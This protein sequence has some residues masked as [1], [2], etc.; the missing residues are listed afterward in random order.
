MKNQLGVKKSLV[1]IVVVFLFLGNG[2]SQN[3]NRNGLINVQE[4]NAVGDGKTDDTQAIQKS[5]SSAQVGDT[6]FI[7]EGKY[8]VKALGL[9]SG[10]HIRAEGLLIQKLAGEREEFS[11]SKQN[12]S[13]P[14]FRGINVSD[15]SLSFKAQ[16]VHEAIYLS[17][18]KRIQI[19]NS[20]I[21]GDSKTLKSFAGILLY[22]CEVIEITK[23]TISHFGSERKSPHTYQPGTAIRI[24]SSKNISVTHNQIL[25]N[26]E[27]GVFMHD[28]PD[29]E[30]SHNKIISNGM[31]AIQV[32]F[33]TNGIE[34]NYRFINN[35]MEDNAADAIDINNRS[36]REF[37]DIHCLIEKNTS[38]N[39]GFVNGESTPDGSGIATL[40]NVSGVRMVDNL[41]EGNN[42]P[43]LYIESCGDIFAT[44]NKADNQVEVV[45]KFN[46]L[47]LKDNTFS[48]ISLL[49]N[50][51]GKKLL[52]THN[53][54][55]SLSLP[56]GIR[57]DSLLIEN[58]HIANAKLNFN[59]EG[60]V[61][62]CENTV[63]S[64]VGDG[65]I[66]V[67]RVNSM[68]IEKNRITSTK[69]HAIAIRKMAKQVTILNNDIKSVNTCILD[70]GSKGLEIKENN[71]LSLEGGRFRHT[72]VSR[73]PDGLILSDNEHL[74]A[75][76]N[77][78]L[79]LEGSGTAWVSGEKIRRGYADY[80]SVVV[81]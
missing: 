19:H 44:G 18:S 15:I 14:L 37:M 10:V 1:V 4:H 13:A 43:A 54:L 42:R 66:L 2:F 75:K 35:L 77:N 59:M 27:N 7:P 6:V 48:I 55:Q 73:N 70:D 49:S 45:L 74:S 81:K 58:N 5:I 61:K 33:G 24:L 3:V 16:T 36:P 23:T 53:Q 72:F 46:E 63:N 71:L 32:A 64:E 69:S 12:S 41:A 31:S 39:N 65:A 57:V 9:K 79:R 8:L 30:V 20:Q 60:N 17:G 52:L 80:G 38:R 56:N 21:Q 11:P 26:G 67:V 62:M 22:N 28:T 47:N 29:V 40:I 76:K 68:H 78:A 34:K 50:V 25:N 51:N